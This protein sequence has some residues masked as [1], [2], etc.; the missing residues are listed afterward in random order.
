MQAVGRVVAAARDDKDGAAAEQSVLREAVDVAFAVFQ[1]P[2]LQVDA[3][4]VVADFHA[5]GGDVAGAD[6]ARDFQLDGLRRRRQGDGHLGRGRGQV[7]DAPLAGE[8]ALHLVQG[9]LAAGQG[10]DQPVADPQEARRIL[11]QAVD[12]QHQGWICAIDAGQ[13][14]GRIAGAQFVQDAARRQAFGESLDRIGNDDDFFRAFGRHDDAVSRRVDQ[15]GD[16]GA[17]CALTFRR[18]GHHDDKGG[19]GVDGG[20]DEHRHGDDFRGQLLRYVAAGGGPDGNRRRQQQPQREADEQQGQRA[21]GYGYR[22][23]AHGLPL[24][25][26]S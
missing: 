5:F 19:I 12:L 21:Q 3:V 11:G 23:A 7:G 16:R 15:A 8:E 2:V 25:M 6:D 20:G 13:L 4:A 26:R 10:D 24:P 14:I 17:V 1:S 22:K 18:R 9:H